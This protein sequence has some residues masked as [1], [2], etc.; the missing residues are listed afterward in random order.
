[1]S[2]NVKKWLSVFAAITML[3][4][5][6]VPA[7]ILPTAAET[8]P[9]Q[10]V[11]TAPSAID[12]TEYLITTST[13]NKTYL[14]F[15]V[16]NHNY[17]SRLIISF[18]YYVVN[19][20]TNQP[21][22]VD[23][24]MLYDE[25]GIRGTKPVDANGDAIDSSNLYFQRRGSG[26]AGFGHYEQELV[27]DSQSSFRFH[28]GGAGTTKVYVWNLSYRYKD[29]GV[30]LSYTRLEEGGNADP[31]LVITGKTLAD[32]DW[33]LEWYY[34]SINDP[35]VTTVD[36][37]KYNPAHA[38]Y[39]AAT[40]TGTNV[41]WLPFVISNGSLSHYFPGADTSYWK[42]D[43][44][45]S[46]TNNDE[47]QWN[48]SFDYYLTNR[49]ANVL[50][51]GIGGSLSYAQTYM[52]YQ[53]Q[54]HFSA[55]FTIAG[56]RSN[57]YPSIRATGFNDTTLYVWNL[58]LTVNGHEV[59][60]ARNDAAYQMADDSAEKVP[61]STLDFAQDFDFA[62][63]TKVS[64]INFSKLPTTVQSTSS[65]FTGTAN[66]GIYALSDGYS[67]SAT[68]KDGEG[69]TTHVL[70]FDYYLPEEC[71]YIVR[72]NHSNFLR[73]DATGDCVLRP[74]Y[75]HFKSTYKTDN[76]NGVRWSIALG[77]HASAPR[78]T[79]PDLY[80]W[81]ASITNGS[82]TKTMPTSANMHGSCTFA[83]TANPETSANFT[84][85]EAVEI[86]TYGDIYPMI[87]AGTNA[88][89]TKLDYSQ[90]T[91]DASKQD[92]S[93]S[94]YTGK[95]T[96]KTGNYVLSFDYYLPEAGTNAYVRVLNSSRPNTYPDAK[97]MDSYTAWLVQ[98]RHKY[99]SENIEMSA[100]AGYEIFLM[101]RSNMTLGTIYIW[102]VSL[103]HVDGSSNHLAGS[104]F[105]AV[106]QAGKVV[107]ITQTQV[108]LAKLDDVANLD[109]LG[110]QIRDG[111]TADLRF[112]GAANV[113][114]VVYNHAAAADYSKA[115][116]V[117]DNVRYKVTEVGML[118]AR[119]KNLTA[120]PEAAL[121]YGADGVS[122]QVAT[123]IQSPEYAAALGVDGI[124]FTTVLTDVPAANMDETISLRTYVK[125][126]DMKG[127]DAYVYGEIISRSYNK[128]VQLATA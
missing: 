76:A 88:T 70:E 65:W 73:D 98:G 84:A 86:V 30:E 27:C 113:D 61:L 94:L 101:M 96:E 54:N 77:K 82:A 59:T 6:L 5:V 18:D 104:H 39:P 13:S 52:L 55:D 12:V 85:A 51:E 105:K 115:T 35:L 3:V 78:E 9:E 24:L 121:T 80:I 49:P 72:T 95:T 100:N 116:V 43:E 99:V 128:T 16:F 45:S 20:N 71:S 117:I 22:Y 21:V 74:G 93:V 67:V 109:N 66:Y 120:L 62:L 106:D 32:Y 81:N 7:G 108:P 83:T 53:G 46:G 79:L 31:S 103:K 8:E 125:Y 40:P 50:L 29:T 1:M 124:A 15:G 111:E 57:A 19:K 112:V 14:N 69:Y 26:V 36:Y 28:D 60:P 122:K 34:D 56:T 38:S 110:T 33:G 102:N 92:Y 114:G 11:V 89:V 25:Q 75:N 10:E 118:F 47:N 17:G 44:N 90:S 107:E 97:P 87:K 63:T 4:S 48:L 68:N 64:K 126:V 58:K 2:K 37:R 91:P 42:S 127:N 123:K 41:R 23:A 119:D